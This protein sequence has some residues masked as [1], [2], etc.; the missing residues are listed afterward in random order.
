MWPTL[1][2]LGV[3]AE[4]NRQLCIADASRG[5]LSADLSIRTRV[6]SLGITDRFPRPATAG[7]KGPLSVS[8]LGRCID[9]RWVHLDISSGGADWALITPT[10]CVVRF[11]G[12]DLVV[13]SFFSIFRPLPTCAGAWGRTSPLVFVYIA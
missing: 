12:C 3:A 5:V 4:A 13:S 10:Q 8:S 11:V 9:P 2:L 7:F 1:T 6:R